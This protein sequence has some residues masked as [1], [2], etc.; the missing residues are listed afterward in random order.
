MKRK[1]TP[2]PSLCPEDLT[3]RETLLLQLLGEREDY[4]QQLINENARLKG[5]KGKPKIKPSRLEPEKKSQQEEGNS[6]DKTSEEN[7][8]KKKRPGSAKRH[9]T[10]SLPIHSTKIIQ[11]TEQIPPDSEF[12]GYQDYTVQELMNGLHGL[13]LHP[14]RIGLISWNC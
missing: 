8:D 1:L 11:P 7:K 5:E 13:K 9:K 2:I 6:E 14:G 12:K 10:A 3:Q 4:I